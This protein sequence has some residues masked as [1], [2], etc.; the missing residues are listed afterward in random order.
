VVAGSR[1]ASGKPQLAS[2][3]HRAIALPSLRYLVH[4]NA[5]GWNVIGSGEYR[6][7]HSFARYDQAFASGTQAP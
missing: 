4:L 7:N 5:P 1:S 2:D 3:P 6:C